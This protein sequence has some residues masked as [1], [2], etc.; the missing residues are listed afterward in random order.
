MLSWHMVVSG[1]FGTIVIIITRL[2]PRSAMPT[3]NK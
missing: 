3:N 2:T 1:N